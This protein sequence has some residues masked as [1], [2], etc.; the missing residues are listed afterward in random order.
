MKIRVV[1]GGISIL[2]IMLFTAFFGE[3]DIRLRSGDLRIADGSAISVDGKSVGTAPCEIVLTPNKRHKIEVTGRDGIVR[4]IYY[5]TRP[6]KKTQLSKIVPPWFLNPDLV[7]GEY[8]GYDVFAT[9][10]ATSR[11]MQIAVNKA[12]QDATVKLLKGNG[13]LYEASTKPVSK[14]ML[15]SSTSKNYPQRT[16]GQMDSMWSSSGGKY[17]V[18]DASGTLSRTLLRSEIQR[19][20]DLFRAYVLVGK[21]N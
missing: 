14:R 8:P 16:R 11:D 12:E 17:I 1:T 9:A 4:T 6:V 2:A 15:D 20:G 10:T 7:R 13:N 18:T 3:G 21:R 5:D 19:I